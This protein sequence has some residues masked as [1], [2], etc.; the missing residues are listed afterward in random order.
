M[1]KA[2]LAMFIVLLLLPKSVLYSQNTARKGIERPCDYELFYSSSDIYLAFDEPYKPNILSKQQ[3]LLAESI[4]RKV[5]DSLN[6]T[7]TSTNVNTQK[8]DTLKHK[9]QIVAAKDNKGQ[10]L[11]WVNA[12]CEPNKEWRKRLLFVDDGGRCYYSFKVNL[13]NRSYY[14]ISVNGNG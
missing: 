2:A 14:E 8:V 1:L 6:F 3:L 5:S 4:I 10:V 11:L 7:I 12:L 13:S 9:F